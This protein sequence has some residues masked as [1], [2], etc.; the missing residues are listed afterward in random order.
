M[1]KMHEAGVYV[2]AEAGSCHDGELAKAYALVEAAKAAGA[3][4]VKFQYWGDAFALANR[5]QS[6]EHYLRIYRR[7]QVPIDWLAP[8]RNKA[9]AQ[10]LDFLCTAYLPDD[11]PVVATLVD[12]F[13][14]ASFEAGCEDLL[15]AHLP[16]VDRD[17][18][19]K[20][21]RC[22]I[23]SMGLGASYERLE[24]LAMHG[25]RAKRIRTLLCVSAYPAPVTD[26]HL[27]RL[28]ADS[29]AQPDGLSDHTAPELTWTGALAVAAGANLIEA[30]LRLF[31]TD[32]QNPDAPHAMTPTQFGAYVTNV[33]FAE[34]CVGQGDATG[35]MPSEHAMARYRAREA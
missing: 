15:T 32:P 20:S 30:H 13:K 3:D 5:R 27:A 35:L 23:V 34:R 2:I 7:Y 6:G 12:H 17:I 22:V 18:A 16:F 21:K 33:R 9:R 8:L 11:V 1:T 4:A 19:N 24:R 10:G 31:D 29:A 25:T 28:W 26:L 14:V